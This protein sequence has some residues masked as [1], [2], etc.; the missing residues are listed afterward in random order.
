MKDKRFEERKKR[1]LKFMGE[2]FYIPMKEKELA[3]V[4]EVEP[5]DR[6]VLKQILV[7]LL[8][9]NRINIS[10]RGKY[11]LGPGK[12]FTGIFSR[13]LKG[14]GFVTVEGGEEFYI[15]EKN[16]L[17]AFSGDSV[18]IEPLSKSH[19]EHKEAKIIEITERAV[20]EVTG[21]YQLSKNKNFGFV[22]PGDPHLEDIF[23]PG[24]FS[25]KAKNNDVVVV[26]ITSYGDVNMKP[27]G[28][29]IEILGKNGDA[30][31]DVL[32]VIRSFSIPESFDTR[33][34][35]EADV[36]PDAV[37][38]EEYEGRRDL[39]NID[40]VT[41]DGEDSKDLDDAVSLYM[42]NDDYILG[43]HIA[44]V[45]HYVREGSEL[46]K[47]ALNRGNSVY[48]VDRVIPMLPVKLSN[49]IC[50]LNAHEDRLAMSCVMRIDEN[51]KIKDYD[52][53]ESVINVNER[54][55]YSSVNKIICE[56]ED[57]RK[58]YS[59]V[60]DMLL[61]MKELSLILRQCRYDR[62]GID[63]D[64]P[65][66]KIEVDETG[67]PV[68]IKAYET[69]AATRLIEDFMLAANECVSSFVFWQDK[70]L[71]YRVHENPDADKID[72]LKIMLKNFGYYLKGDAENI[73]PKE[74]QKMLM[75]F[76]GH[77]EEGMITR[78]TLRSM[79][80]ARY[81]PECLGHFGLA[82]KQYCHFTSPI[83]RY[84]DLVVHRIVKDILH[85]DLN[86]KKI[87]RYNAVLDEIC[88]QC[89]KTER[90]ADE[91]ERAVNKLKKAQYME[92]HIG[93]V[94]E[95]NI[96]GLTK[97]GMYVELPNTIEGMIRISKIPGDYFEYD[98]KKMI[99]YGLKS[100]IVYKLCQSV[101]VRVEDVD[102]HLGTIDFE[103]E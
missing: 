11:S 50:S 27:E 39:R 46:D 93:E 55:T 66:T 35:C 83:R 56:D 12:T 74:I 82:C 29:V 43:V 33:V 97:Y 6:P 3:I 69:N 90:R 67:F 63:F 37:M 40:M 61:K 52:I 81:S 22:I 32:S 72:T 99:M 2:S 13:T 7:E 44:D 96:S 77:E 41:I 58:K 57:E 75:E 84:P 54:M 47:S 88:K 62:G 80:K 48:F 86:E 101:K 85:G 14:F 76:E 45:S 1:I 34:S 100:D 68:V 51:G 20:T 91:A 92:R 98:D 18:K 10:K 103:L 53:F 65:E 94:F 70:P 49:G 30:G 5:E 36:L 42:D 24:E 9:E 8:D 95:G 38:K 102:I 89:S 73:H 60:T 79:K 28:K 17:N 64:I 19:G 78:L 25:L 31:V 26:S 87:N 16:S 4:L 59:N 23:I 15:S 21:T 71:V